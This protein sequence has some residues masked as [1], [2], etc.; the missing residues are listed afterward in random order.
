MSDEVDIT[1]L[2]KLQPQHQWVF[3]KV[4]GELLTFHRVQNTTTDL[5]PGAFGI[6]EPNG[7]TT[8]SVADIDVFFCPG[9][10]FDP[11]GGRIGRGRG[12]YDR[13]LAMARSDAH[14]IGVCFP[15]QLV[16]T[17]FTEDHDVVMD[18]VMSGVT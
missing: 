16:P 14:K 13:M 2:V 6:L 17:T 8:V 5:T 4:D 10:A 11:H 15:E 12:F 1:P 9:L 18:E 3:P 7:G